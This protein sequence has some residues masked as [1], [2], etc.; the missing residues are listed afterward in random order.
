MLGIIWNYV[1]GYK[2]NTLMYIVGIAFSVALMFSMIQ[3]GNRL[4]F[5]FKQML[6]AAESYDFQVYD[7]DTN[8]IDR[9]YAYLENY[10]EDILFMKRIIYGTSRFEDNLATIQIAGVEGQWSNLLNTELVAGAYP[11]NENEIC[12][13]EKYCIYIGVNPEDMIDREISLNVEDDDGNETVL[14]YKVVG[15]ISNAPTSYPVYYMYTTYQSAIETIDVYHFSHNQE[16]NSLVVMLETYDFDKEMNLTDDIT[17]EFGTEARF[18]ANHIRE[19]EEKSEIYNEEGGYHTVEVVFYGISVFIG[20]CLAIFVYNIILMNM[21]Q[22]IQQ[23]GIMRCIGM[24]NGNLLVLMLGEI[25]FYAIFGLIIGMLSG[26]V[27]NYFVANKIIKNL[28]DIEVGIYNHSMSVYIFTILLT[29]AAIIFAFAFIFGKLNKLKP[30]E[31]TRYIE[32]ANSKLKFNTKINNNNVVKSMAVLNLQRNKL[33]SK[34]LFITFVISATIII[35]LFNVVALIDVKRARAK[36]QF[37]DYEVYSDIVSQKYISAADIERL[38]NADGVNQIYCQKID[39]EYLC[40]PDQNNIYNT[41]LVVYSDNLYEKFIKLNHIKNVDIIHDDVAVVF[42]FGDN[43]YNCTYIDISRT[44]DYLEENARENYRIKVNDIRYDGYSLLGGSVISEA[45][46]AYLIINENLAE[47]IY[48]AMEQY[49]DILIDCDETLDE[50]IILSYMEGTTCVYLKD[51]LETG[52]AQLLGMS[53]MCLYVLISVILLSILIINSTIKMNIVNR[54]KEIGMLRS[55]GAEEVTVRNMLCYEIMSLAVKAVL[56]ACVISI[57]VCL[58][59][60]LIL[61]DCMN[62]KPIGY[63]VGVVIVL[64]GSY[65]ITHRAVITNMSTR[66]SEMLRNE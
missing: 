20:V 43:Q 48:G 14:T 58:Y 27:L 10:D 22:K 9:I 23:Y 24:N 63:I 55:I 39:I 45:E 19:N 33:N 61:N 28:L 50:N 35:V 62:I 7:L 53:Y 65:I 54:I 37:A 31:M 51:V 36:E 1:K 40:E 52:R 6:L 47:K 30:I 17:N 41:L 18:Y 59:I 46:K 5:Q 13:E 12:V 25:L 56:L 49:T 57:P 11:L 16:Y 34:I 38:E 66:I 29:L 21:T 60:S 3:M 42:S 64:A 26:N 2:R 44:N 4:L 32:M 15:V 8:Q